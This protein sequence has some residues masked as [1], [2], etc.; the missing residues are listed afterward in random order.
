M[1]TPPVTKLSCTAGTAA[2][3]SL[4]RHR[5]AIADVTCRMTRATLSYA[6]QST[7][8]MRTSTSLRRPEQRSSVVEALP[9]SH[10]PASVALN[11]GD[12]SYGRHLRHLVCCIRKPTR[13]KCRDMPCWSVHTTASIDSKALLV[14]TLVPTF[15]PRL[16][17]TVA[18]RG[19]VPHPSV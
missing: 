6:A 11:T 5:A 2:D 13:Q 7:V 1:V 18:G 12:R 14:Y 19:R 17:A 3:S 16:P 4:L 8:C 15:L 10:S 9:H